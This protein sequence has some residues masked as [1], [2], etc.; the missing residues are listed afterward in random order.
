MDVVVGKVPWHYRDSEKEGYKRYRARGRH[1]GVVERTMR[2]DRVDND[3]KT[4]Q[5]N[6]KEQRNNFNME[7]AYDLGKTSLCMLHSAAIVHIRIKMWHTLRCDM[8]KSRLLPR[9]TIQDTQ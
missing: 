2:K 9:A 5:G 3:N 8:R 1:C 4:K 7:D 6:G